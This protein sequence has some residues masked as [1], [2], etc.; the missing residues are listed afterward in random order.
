MNDCCQAALYAMATPSH[1]PVCGKALNGSPYADE[2][3]QAARTRPT[4]RDREPS[5][6]DDD[7]AYF[8]GDD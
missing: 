7:D 5:W 8:D 4:S 2:L 6:S 3:D 1:C